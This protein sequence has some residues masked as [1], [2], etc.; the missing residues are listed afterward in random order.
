MGQKNG[1]REL[2]RTDIKM[3]YSF[4]IKVWTEQ[5]VCISADL[6]SS[7]LA[8]NCTRPKRW[9][10]TV[11]KTHILCVS[12]ET[13]E[14][15]QPNWLRHTLDRN[16]YLPSSTY[17]ISQISNGLLRFE[18]CYAIQEP[19]FFYYYYTSS[20]FKVTYNVCERS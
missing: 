18:I 5:M 9:C 3:L 15:S 20:P 1:D 8:H 13:C 14:S 11:N 7:L 2:E 19:H 12:F 6:T 16:R 17:T 4:L 10:S